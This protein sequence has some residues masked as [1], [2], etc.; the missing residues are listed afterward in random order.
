[1]RHLRP[2]Q[3]VEL[4]SGSSSHV[5]DTA[6][7]RNEED[8]SPCEHRVFDPYPWEATVL[9][10]VAGATVVPLGARAVDV[11]EFEALGRDDILFVDTT[12]TVKTGG[13][14]NRIVLELLPRLA[15]GV[16]VHFHDIFLPYEYPRS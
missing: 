9:G 8:G 7:R 6:R 4:G 13:D 5:I 14:V 16:L 10:P 11:S 3:V 15:P 12:H 2:A 1:M